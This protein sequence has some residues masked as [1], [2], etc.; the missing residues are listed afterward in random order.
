MTNT[1]T[2]NA[3]TNTTTLFQHGTLALLVPGLFDGTLTMADLRKHGDTGIGTGDGLDGEIIM[4]NGTPYQV[5]HD[6]SIVVVPDDLTLPFANAHV[7]DFQPFTDISDRSMS[8]VTAWLSDAAGWANTFFA[9]L[10]TGDFAPM[11]TRAVGKQGKPYPTLLQSAGAQSVFTAERTHGTVLAYHS[12][13]LFHGVAVGGFH[14]HY[15]AD[16]HAIGGHV[17]DFHVAHAQ[18]S[19]QRFDTFE[20]HLPVT[21][22]AFSTHD[23]S[24]DDIAEDVRQSE[25]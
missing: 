15:L 14:L 2:S 18:V 23:F 12:P 13:Q 5:R 22:H 8:Q 1:T 24:Q 9:A 17:L 7:A 25:G 6:G 16:D 3:T 21:N 10:I 11:R 20:E 4:L 19:L